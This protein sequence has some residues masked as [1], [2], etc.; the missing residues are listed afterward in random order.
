MLCCL[1]ILRFI[2]RINS[3]ATYKHSLL[4]G[5][6]YL[7]VIPLLS[8]IVFADEKYTVEH[9]LAFSSILSDICGKCLH[10]HKIVIDC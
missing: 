6:F 2:R 4:D 3:L 10:L 7:Q 5:G 9:P 8:C 1:L